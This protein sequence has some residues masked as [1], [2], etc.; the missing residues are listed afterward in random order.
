MYAT[1]FS[2]NDWIRRIEVKSENLL[3]NYSTGFRKSVNTGI[4]FR[5]LQKH[6]PAEI[7]AIVKQFFQYD[8]I[9]YDAY[10]LADDAGARMKKVAIKHLLN[11]TEKRVKKRLPSRVGRPKAS[12][13]YNYANNKID[14][15]ERCFAAMEQMESAGK[16]LTLGNLADSLYPA[17]QEQKTV[18]YPEKA[19]R[20][21][22]KKYAISF[23]RLKGAYTKRGPSVFTLRESLLLADRY[24]REHGLEEI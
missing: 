18:N 10:S 21:Q 1:S 4:F 20:N 19:I 22:L 24:E 23:E 5:H 3:E 6:L 15:V 17:D 7:E 2:N 8:S 9:I 14:F 11:E 12:L 16:K 13:G